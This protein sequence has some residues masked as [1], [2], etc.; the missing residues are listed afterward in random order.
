MQFIIKLKD[1]DKLIAQGIEGE[2][3]ER[4]EGHWYFEPEAVDMQYLKETQRTYTCP[5]KG[6]CNWIDL[7]APGLTARN[8]AWVYHQPL[9]GYEFIRDRIAFYARDTTGTEAVQSNE[10]SAGTATLAEQADSHPK[11]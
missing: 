3:V 11:R 10:T 1:S 9:Q 6:V 2:Q 8:I 5:Y 7:E 4:F